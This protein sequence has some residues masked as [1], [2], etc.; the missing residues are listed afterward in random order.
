ML[1]EVAVAK[2]HLKFKEGNTSAALQ[3]ISVDMLGHIG[4]EEMTREV[5]ASV[6]K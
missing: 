2:A 5:Q 1:M 6:F 3:D 4:S